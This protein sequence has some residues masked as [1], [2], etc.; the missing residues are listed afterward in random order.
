MTATKILTTLKAGDSSAFGRTA[1]PPVPPE[2]NAG[3]PVPAPANDG[4]MELVVWS[5]PAVNRSLVICHA[6]EADGGNP[7][8]LVSLRVRDNTNFLK[9]MRVR[10]RRETDRKFSLEGPCPRWRG[11]W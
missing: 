5:V 4:L 7:M 2:K 9:N 1:F 11:K 8:N 6:P 3:A 10:A